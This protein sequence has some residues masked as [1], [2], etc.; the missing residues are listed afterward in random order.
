M[1]TNV[2]PCYFHILWDHELNHL[3]HLLGN[4]LKRR[5]EVMKLWHS[6][7]AVHFGDSR[8]LSELEFAAVFGSELERSISDLLRKD[9]EGFAA[10]VRAETAELVAHEGGPYPEVIV[11]M[12]LF[13][14]SVATIFPGFPP[15][16]PRPT[17]QRRRHTRAT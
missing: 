17:S 11:S 4:L 7:Y 1:S 13:E 5:T 12:H 10:K 8:A 9:M 6:R 16:L 14:E 15:A 2:E 3:H